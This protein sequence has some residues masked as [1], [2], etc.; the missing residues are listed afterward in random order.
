MDA[1]TLFRN[2]Q[3]SVQDNKMLGGLFRSMQESETSRIGR[4]SERIAE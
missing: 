4:L 1:S 3:E 2:F